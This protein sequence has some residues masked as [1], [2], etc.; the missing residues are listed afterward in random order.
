M[1]IPAIRPLA[2]TVL[3]FSSVAAIAQTVPSAGTPYTAVKKTT[4]IR[5]LAD[6]T[7]INRENSTTE[8]RD[9]QGR[10]MH[11]NLVSQVQGQNIINTNVLDP[12]ARTNTFWMSLGK[13]AT[14]IHMPDLR[15]AAQ[16]SG[17]TAMGLGSGPIGAVSS[18]T[19]HSQTIRTGATGTAPETTGI[20]TMTAGSVRDPNLRPETKT[21]KLGGKTIA[22]VYAEG[23]RLTVN[24]PVGFFGND[25][26][27][28]TFHETWMSSD[29]KL[30]VLSVDDDPRTGTR[31][32]EVTNLD[33]GEPNPALFQVPEGYTIRDQYPGTN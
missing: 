27:I 17:P 4:I 33:R 12:V 30:V 18:A 11:Q 3:L 32:T 22:G 29:L 6:G 14:R 23:T 13:E 21:E 24:Y 10:T 9:S 26:P 25:K 31:I 8:A 20:V 5:K 15:R 7:T 1:L 28:I 2:L 19:S 16:Q